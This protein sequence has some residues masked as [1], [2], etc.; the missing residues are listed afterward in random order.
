M[1][2]SYAQQMASNFSS[3]T[4]NTFEYS[5]GL[6]PPASGDTTQWLL[7]SLASTEMDP[8]Q[9]TLVNISML[10]SS[11]YTEVAVLLAR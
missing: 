11:E 4:V 7:D 10:F 6:P 8:L 2:N 1:D 5:L 9:Y 3:L